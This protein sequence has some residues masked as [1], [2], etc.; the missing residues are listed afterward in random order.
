MPS[1]LH[2]AFD[3]KIVINKRKCGN[4]LTKKS[5]CLGRY[6]EKTREKRRLREIGNYQLK[7][8]KK[9]IDKMVDPWYNIEG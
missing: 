9:G 1:L 2:R 6:R 4:N 7:Y 8:F 5:N 3:F